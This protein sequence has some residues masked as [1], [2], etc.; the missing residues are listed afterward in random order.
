M[1]SST[2]PVLRR[3]LHFLQ[4][5]LAASQ[6][7][8]LESLLRR[9][10]QQSPSND[11][12]TPATISSRTASPPAQ[13]HASEPVWT[14][15]T[16][17]PPEPVVSEREAALLARIAQLESH[18]RL[19]QASVLASHT[20]TEIPS[21]PAVSPVPPMPAT[22]TNLPPPTLAAAPIP[23]CDNDCAGQ[24]SL[25]A[26]RST[27]SA[28][29][30]IQLFEAHMAK[31][32]AEARARN[33]IST[34]RATNDAEANTHA[35]SQQQQLQAPAINTEDTGT[36][37]ADPCESPVWTYQHTAVNA[38]PSFGLT[39]A[40]CQ[41][42]LTSGSHSRASHSSS[43]TSSSSHTRSPS[44][45]V[46]VSPAGTTSSHASPPPAA[47]A[48]AASATPQKAGIR[49]LRA[50]S[51]QCEYS[52]IGNG[53][54][55]LGVRSTNLVRLNWAP[56]TGAG[57][58]TGADVRAEPQNVLIIK[59]P[60]D[61]EVSRALDDVALWLHAHGK[62]VWV[63]P[64]VAYEET[65][66]VASLPFLQTWSTPHELAELHL[67]IDL[68]ICLGGDGTLLFTSNL[69]KTSVPPVI[70]FSFGSLGFLSP[71]S[72]ENFP[73]A[74]TK[75]FQG[76]FHLTL[77]SRL[78]CTIV[79]GKQGGG[80]YKKT[81]EHALTGAAT[82]QTG[83]LARGISD[84]SSAASSP[85][86]T[87]D[88]TTPRP[89]PPSLSI[90][91]AR[92]YSLSAQGVNM[93]APHYQT[94]LPVGVPSPTPSPVPAIDLAAAAAAVPKPSPTATT[95]NNLSSPSRPARSAHLRSH[96]R[97][98]GGQTVGVELI[99][100]LSDSAD[101]LPPSTSSDINSHPL[102]SGPS[103]APRSSE[104]DMDALAADDV[105]SYVCL[106][107]VIM[108]RG[109]SA[110]LT[111]L[112]CYVDGMHF[113]RVQADG[114]IVGTPTGS[115]AYSLS[116]GG[117]CCHPEVP[118]MLFTPVCPHSLSF[119]PLLFPDTSTLQIKVSPD[120]RGTNCASFDGR[121]RTALH[122]GDSLLISMSRWPVPSICRLDGTTDWFDGVRRYAHTRTRA[123]H[124]RAPHA[125]TRRM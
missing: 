17:P 3:F 68:V 89:S 34:E 51:R 93:S 1:C 62:T 25:F 104:D 41:P 8:R 49:L 92:H 47:P 67:R 124:T 65:I 100:D 55:S 44:P 20:T 61:A 76:G 42:E 119:R 118:C 35:A 48:A 5:L 94:T 116:A 72:F 59:K 24:V 107:E 98:G 18:N 70:S 125:R 19:L 122:P 91:K 45:S 60:G 85:P 23:P 64:A 15:A 21:A 26:K 95:A 11:S 90:V 114:I 56:P 69:F 66:G 16:S 53:R 52:H 111:L 39:E 40:R 86:P 14:P 106:N 96:S 33:A 46:S 105:E 10:E 38:P 108:E 9:L 82:L 73:A 32:A 123:K 58:S 2:L 117:T 36:T 57:A 37:T 79:R 102:T 29:I 54:I 109:L 71:F 4:V 121:H 50:D 88:Q 63:E 28:S 115:T 78:V 112:D 31:G 84:T 74:L 75:V 81:R 12:H 99:D 77:R 97:Y 22:S 7:D 83:V 27:R 120:S 80:G 113:T 103:T 110:Y 6:V 43:Q 87:N 30:E 101:P 13:L